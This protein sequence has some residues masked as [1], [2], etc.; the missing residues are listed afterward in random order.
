M[1]R[2]IKRSKFLSF[3]HKMC[4]ESN[5]PT[6]L[7]RIALDRL[8]SAAAPVPHRYIAS[9]I[10][11]LRGQNRIAYRVS[12]GKTEGRRLPRGHRRRWENT[13]A[14]YIPGVMQRPR[15]NREPLPSNGLINKNVFTATKKYDNEDLYCLCGPWRDVTS[16]NNYWVE[17]GEKF[18]WDSSVE[19][20]QLAESRYGYGKGTVRKPRERG[21]YTVGSCYQKTG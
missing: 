21:T 3:P 13:I 7:W 2:G 16:G 12:V 6:S 4:R 18:S 11:E 9:N 5:F 15:K 1:I 8:Q 19:K 20:G 10:S 17:W 14:K